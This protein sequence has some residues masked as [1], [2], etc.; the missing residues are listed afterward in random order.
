VEL[1]HEG[2]LRLCVRRRQLSRTRDAATRTPYG[3]MDPSPPGN[4]ITSRCRATAWS[5]PR[6][7]RH[8]SASGSV[9]ELRA[10]VGLHDVHTEGQ[11]A[12]D[13][14]DEPALGRLGA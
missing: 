13:F 4:H 2:E 5:I 1:T 9:T 11:P 7:A 8:S 6:R 3:R 10:V 14:V 12:K